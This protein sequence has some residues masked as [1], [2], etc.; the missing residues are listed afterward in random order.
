MLYLH[1]SLYAPYRD[2][3]HV[4]VVDDLPPYDAD[5]PSSPAHMNLGVKTCDFSCFLRLIAG[6]PKITKLSYH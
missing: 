3:P 2:I 1:V 6:S 4:V 5:I